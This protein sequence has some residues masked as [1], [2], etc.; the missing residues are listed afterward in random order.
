MPRMSAEGVALLGYGRFGR[1]LGQLLGEAGLP[2]RAHDPEAAVPREYGV[3]SLRELT[4]GVGFVVLAVPVSRMRQVLLELRPRL[5]GEQVVFDVGSVKVRPALAL[6]EIL[7]SEIPWC[8]THPLFG[9]VSLAL[10]E[11]PLR[12]LLCPA[13]AHPPAPAPFPPLHPRIPA[14]ATHQP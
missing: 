14:P 4:D 12:A 7:G 5:S 3:D 10:A 6:S 13:P 2:H 8:A 1:A 11:R 9:P